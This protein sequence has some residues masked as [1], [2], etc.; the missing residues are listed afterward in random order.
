MSTQSLNSALKNH[1]PF[2]FETL[3][4]MTRKKHLPDDFR[5]FDPGI[6]TSLSKNVKI[7][8][9]Q[10][11]SCTECGISF[12]GAKKLLLEHHKTHVRK[13]KNEKKENEVITGRYLEYF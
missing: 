7:E 11:H 12:Y 13:P 9:F 6:F 2:L 5:P 3:L 4:D 8:P 10:N 1:D